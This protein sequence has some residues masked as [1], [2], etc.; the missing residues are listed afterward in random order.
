MLVTMEACPPTPGAVDENALQEFE[1]YDAVMQTIRKVAKGGLT[2][3]E[4]EHLLQEFKKTFD[5]YLEQP[6][7]LDGHLAEIVQALVKPVKSPDCTDDVLHTC[8]VFLVVV[9]Q[10]RG[11]KVVVNHLPHEVGVRGHGKR[12]VLSTTIGATKFAFPA[13]KNE[14]TGSANASYRADRSG[15]AIGR[16]LTCRVES[17]SRDVVDSLRIDVSVML[18][19][20]VRYRACST[21]VLQSVSVKL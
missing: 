4:I 20:A 17:V 18:H 6:Y 1:D 19:T 8:M 14:I 11:Y 21:F 2:E 9:T 15:Q 16:I 13:A 7:L 5:K 3:R 10:V 12:T